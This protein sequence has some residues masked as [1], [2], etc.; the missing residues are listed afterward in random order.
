[1]AHVEMLGIP[2]DDANHV[3]TLQAAEPRHS[4][5]GRLGERPSRCGPCATA[6]GCTSPRTGMGIPPPTAMIVAYARGRSCSWTRVWTEGQY[7][8][9]SWPGVDAP[10]GPQFLSVQGRSSTVAFPA[11]N[12][13]R[14]G[15]NPRALASGGAPTG[16]P[17]RPALELHHRIDKLRARARRGAHG[18]RPLL[19]VCGGGGA[20][21]TRRCAGLRGLLSGRRPCRRQHRGVV[22]GPKILFGGCL[23]KSEAAHR[24]RQHRGCRPRVVAARGAGRARSL[25][26]GGRRGARPG[27]AGT[28][29]LTT[30]DLAHHP[31]RAVLPPR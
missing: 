15:A 24:S 2:P 6:T 14:R 29:G 4:R 9:A 3:A 12:P 26:D 5:I 18:R 19:T 1:V 8:S 30:L 25:S 17:V 10:V 11:A 28:T 31:D 23:V 27:A 16:I 13:W 7:R 21:I 20:R 22:P